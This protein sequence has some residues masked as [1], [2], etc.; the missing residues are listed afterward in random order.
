M[1]IIFIIAIIVVIII[2][3]YYYAYLFI[4]LYTFPDKAGKY[5][6]FRSVHYLYLA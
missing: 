6:I 5:R 3:A 4:A 1:I 2:L